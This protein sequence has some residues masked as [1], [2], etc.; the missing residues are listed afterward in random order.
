MGRELRGLRSSNVTKC[1][2]QLANLQI[3]C[4]RPELAFKANALA[5]RA[6]C[7]RLGR[8]IMD[9]R[10]D[11]ACLSNPVN[12][13][14]QDRIFRRCDIE[15]NTAAVIDA[16][17]DVKNPAVSITNSFVRQG[18]RRLFGAAFSASLGARVYE[19]HML[20]R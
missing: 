9:E 16:A 2:S 4:R 6:G 20:V 15:N 1:V 5:E 8:R 14:E 13:H 3:S 11:K 17:T 7:V 10:F 19:W 12:P 18:P